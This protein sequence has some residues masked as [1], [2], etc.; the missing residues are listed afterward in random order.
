MILDIA[1]LILGII[2]IATG[3]NR[4][5]LATVFSIVGYV[6]GGV[7]GF[8][9]ANWYTSEWKGLASIIALHLF[10]IF[11]GASLGRWVLERTG[12]GIHKRILFGPFKFLNAIGGATLS[13]AQAALAAFVIIT[14]I[15][16][17]PWEIPHSIIKESKVYKEISDFNLLS[18]QI[19][20]LLRST[21][22]RWDQL[23]S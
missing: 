5:A 21:S 17:L 10:G 11:V 16:Y 12:I 2:A 7:A 20:D 15:D 23:K 19:S 22:L 6:G 3:Y 9:A 13:L 1:L 8:A 4:G 18:F 14:L